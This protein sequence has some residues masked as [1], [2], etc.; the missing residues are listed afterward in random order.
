MSS[1]IE[2][3]RLK[4]FV[5]IKG[6]LVAQSAFLTQSY[7]NEIYDSIVLRDAAGRPYVPGTSLAGAL[8]VRMQEA[9]TSDA[10]PEVVEA[11]FGSE[12]R[13]KAGS[14]PSND[15]GLQSALIVNECYAL[16]EDG[17]EQRISIR[18]GIA[19]S[20]DERTV[21][22]RALYDYEVVEAGAAYEL[23]L[24]LIV[25]DG[26][27]PAEQVALLDRLVKTL[28]DDDLIVGAKGSRGLGRFRL[29]S[30]E[31]YVVKLS[32]DGARDA[33]RDFD[34]STSAFSP[35]EEVGGIQKVLTDS[36][37]NTESTIT[38]LPPCWDV[39]RYDIKVPGSLLIRDYRRPD[40]MADATMLTT[41]RYGKDEQASNGSSKPVRYPL[42][43][44]TSWG[45]LL[46]G[47]VR[48]VLKD[49]FGLDASVCQA[50]LARCFG[51]DYHEVKQK[52]SEALASGVLIDETVVKKCAYTGPIDVTRTALD[53]FT[54][55][56]VAGHLFTD[57]VIVAVT[58][59]LTVRYPRDDASRWM[60]QLV[61]LALL[62]VDEGFAALGGEVSVGRG[63]VEVGSSAMSVR[64][65][66]KG[67]VTGV[68]DLLE[69][70]RELEDEV[71]DLDKKHE[72]EKARESNSAPE[73]EEAVAHG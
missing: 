23:R 38:P 69:K 17:R 70:I 15:E 1:I 50:L 9:G 41:T 39:V 28:L 25:R 43:P 18:D 8:R 10:P 36:E 13:E 40:L 66:D 35:W 62:D 71:R 16:L 45:G 6:K 33:Y 54:G 52:K 21:A 57:G 73:S 34:W 60:R 67:N 29:E 5:W 51:A 24:E 49:D 27:H 2:R 61:E 58:A 63:L 46:R 64:M 11:M 31:V 32:D 59:Q 72:L 47:A 53:R 26:R 55:G 4:A 48:R 56:V 30:P 19:L 68:E 37:N 12:A 44:G 20:E 42:I 3:N 7:D 65:D 22:P 14:A